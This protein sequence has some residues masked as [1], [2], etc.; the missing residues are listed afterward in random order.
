MRGFPSLIEA[1]DKEHALDVI[2]KHMRV[3]Y[4][5]VSKSYKRHSAGGTQ[6]VHPMTQVRVGGD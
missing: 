4:D 5:H 3:G 1:G 2:D 6:Y